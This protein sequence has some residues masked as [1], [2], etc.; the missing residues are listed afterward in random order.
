MGKSPSGVS[1]WSQTLLARRDPHLQLSPYSSP[2][3]HL[4]ASA[5]SLCE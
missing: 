1:T 5:F 4:S 2:T 3:Q